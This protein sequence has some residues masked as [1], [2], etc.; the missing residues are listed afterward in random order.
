MGREGGMGDRGPPSSLS[1]VLWNRPASVSEA[2][3]RPLCLKPQMLLHPHRN[4]LVSWVRSVATDHRWYPVIS[5]PEEVA[6]E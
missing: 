3:D 1:Q 5:H 2:P 4:Q 6:T